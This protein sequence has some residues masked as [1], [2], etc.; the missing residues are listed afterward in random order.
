MVTL[1]QW[2][3]S[4]KLEMPKL[5]SFFSRSVCFKWN[6][7]ITV[8]YQNLQMMWFVKPEVKMTK[9]GCGDYSCP[10]SRNVTWW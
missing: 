7:Q 6:K 1:Q 10:N 5:S 8:V 4:F 9:W 2:L 3:W